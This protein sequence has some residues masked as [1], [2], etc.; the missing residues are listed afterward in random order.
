MTIKYGGKYVDNKLYS[1]YYFVFLKK[2]SLFTF[3]LRLHINN[4]Q[5]SDRGWY[6][7]QINTDPM[8]S[9]RGFLEVVGKIIY[10]YITYKYLSILRT[11]LFIYYRYPS[12]NAFFVA[13]KKPRY[14]KFAL[15]ES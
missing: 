13:D 7:C 1:K 14:V 10:L 15:W 5:E 8:V 11:Q 12:A 6:M 4:I 2:L 3:V 9:E